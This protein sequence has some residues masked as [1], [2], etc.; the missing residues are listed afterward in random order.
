MADRRSECLSSLGS[1][2]TSAPPAFHLHLASQDAVRLV[3]RTAINAFTD[4]TRKNCAMLISRAESNL[5]G[6]WLNVVLFSLQRKKERNKE[7]DEK[8]NG[9]SNLDPYASDDDDNLH[10]DRNL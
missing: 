4:T 10:G 2:V 8:P 6:C 7:K 9:V 5:Y 1:T 3:V